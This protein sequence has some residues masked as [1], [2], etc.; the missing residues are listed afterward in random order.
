MQPR[1]LVRIGPSHYH[2]GHIV[3]AMVAKEMTYF[4]EEGLAAYD[5]ASRASRTSAASASASATS[6]AST[7]SH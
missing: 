5:L 3:P 1:N 4:E 6:A 7:T 2:V